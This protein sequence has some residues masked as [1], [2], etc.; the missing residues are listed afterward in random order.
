MP[1]GSTRH[2]AARALS[3]AALAVAAAV[4]AVVLL[5]ASGKDYRVHVILENAS[6]LVRGNEAKVGG[7]EVGTIDE[8]ELDERNRARVTVTIDDDDLA[9]LHDG[10]TATVRATSLSGVANRYLALAPGPNSSPRI[11]D[12]GTINAQDTHSAVDLDAILNTLDLETR[13]ALGRAVRASAIQYSGAEEEANAGLH[14]LNP[15][16]AQTA[17]TSRELVRD[18]DAFERFIV[19]SAAVVSAVGSRDRDLS[20]GI[21]RAAAV[22]DAVAR[23]R[24]SLNTILAGAPA[25]LRRAN[26]TL[27]NARA[28]L[29]DLRPALREAR[30]VAPRLARVMR[31]LEP[32]ARRG[33]PV[34][35]D[36]RRLVPE[37]TA[38]LR[39][40]PALERSAVPAVDSARSALA[41][42]APVVAAARPYLPDVVAGLLNGFGGTT[43]G[44][45]DANGH[46]TRI[47]F[48]GGP[49]SLA[50]NASLIPIPPASAT[51]QGYRRGIFARCPGAATQPAPDRSNPFLTPEAPCRPEDSP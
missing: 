9:P 18:T 21:V 20:Q 41:E 45:Y 32:V 19:E 15:A 22:T 36:V 49:Y 46:Y 51:L 50:Q 7:H 14:A 8:I 12:G 38:A 44:Y 43:A 30:P 48:Q 35:A 10:T 27:V 6:Q 4:L 17:Q 1:V 47:S 42:A 13:N 39:G 34:V 2:A 26:S 3:L 29:R 40:L 23:E 11:P 25:T 16:L 33:R 31:V 28:A 37:L 24:A 5:G